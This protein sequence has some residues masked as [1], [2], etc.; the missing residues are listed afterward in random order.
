[1][2]SASSCVISY[3]FEFDSGKSP[4]SGSP[5]SSEC[6]DWLV[7]GSVGIQDILI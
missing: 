6:F 5:G 3:V 7:E 1:M 4:P 2:S